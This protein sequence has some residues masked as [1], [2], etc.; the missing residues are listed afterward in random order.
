VRNAAISESQFKPHWPK[1]TER[2]HPQG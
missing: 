1:G 2:T